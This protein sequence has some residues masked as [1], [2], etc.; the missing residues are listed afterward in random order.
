VGRAEGEPGGGALSP[1]PFELAYDFKSAASSQRKQLRF[2][3]RGQ[4]AG[5]TSAV[6]VTA[7]RLR[8][9]LNAKGYGRAAARDGGR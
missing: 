8:F 6:H 4:A 3:S 2:G 7:A 5:L 1:V 9:L